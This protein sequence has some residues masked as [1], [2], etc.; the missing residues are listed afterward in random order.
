MP[1]HRNVQRRNGT[2]IYSASDLN[3]YLEC[4]HLTG[5]RRRLVLGEVSAPDGD[6]DQRQRELLSRKG[7]EH[8]QRYLAKLIASGASVEQLPARVGNDESFAAAQDRTLA[9]IERGPA[10]I[11]QP[12]FYDGTFL[13][14]A[15]FLRRI[16]RPCAARGWSYEVIDTKL[17]RSTKAYFLVQLS[18][19][20]QHLAGLQGGTMP[21]RMHVALGSGEERSFFTRDY[22]AYYRHL[23]ASFLARAG[24]G[25]TYPNECGHCKVCD[26]ERTCDRQRRDDDHLS[27][28]AWMRRDQ[29]DKLTNGGIA[30]L[31]ELAFAPDDAR[32]LGFNPDTFSGLRLQA[33][34]QVAGRTARKHH[35]LPYESRGGLALLPAPDEGDVY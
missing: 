31:T 23:R 3:D 9:A 1:Y 6:A 11:F 12:T 22:L 17:A 20:S 35:L 26:W 15:D 34:L 27:L 18:S 25:T 29:S 2:L 13:G 7:D 5:L 8:E 32:P 30:T 19:Y 33:S 21:E 28:V 16:D 14:R 4:P 10:Y 24:N